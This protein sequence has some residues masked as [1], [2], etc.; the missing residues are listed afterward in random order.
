MM[1][2]DCIHYGVCFN[3]CPDALEDG[4][5]KKGGLLER[6]VGTRKRNG[7]C[8]SCGNCVKFSDTALGCVVRDKFIMPEFPPYYGSLKCKDWKAKGERNE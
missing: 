3:T 6:A 1:C 8:E 5:L 2:K 4:R 7:I